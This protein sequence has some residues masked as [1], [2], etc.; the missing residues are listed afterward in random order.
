MTTA[1]HRPPAFGGLTLEPLTEIHRAALKAACAEDPAIWSIYSVDYG[2]DGFDATFSALIGHPRR[3][4]FAILDD[5]RLAGMSAY[6]DPEPARAVV[7][8]GNTYL[9]PA[10]RG[11]GLNAW[12]KTLMIGHAFAC[13]FRRIEFRVDARNIRSQAA[14]AKIG[15]VREGVLRQERVTWTGHVRD[16]VLFSIL[17]GEW[18]EAQGSGAR[19]R[20]GDER[21]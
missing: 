21:P 15:G 16:T 14:V 2:P 7:E 3:I 19:K 13:R 18:D 17:R 4:P 1:L 11:T 8:I 9:R 10:A 12:L 20:D 5:G 6:I